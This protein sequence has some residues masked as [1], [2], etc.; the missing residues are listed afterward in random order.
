MMRTSVAISAAKLASELLDQRA[1]G[2]HLDVEDFCRVFLGEALQ[3]NQQKR[4]ARL[5]RD[6]AKPLL[7]GLLGSR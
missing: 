2:R 4:L 7:D 6:L 5:C 3:R 1:Q